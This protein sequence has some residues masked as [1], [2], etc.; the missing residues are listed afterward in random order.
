MTAGMNHV[1]E[2]FVLSAVLVV[3]TIRGCDT[4]RDDRIE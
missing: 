1:R 3:F 4:G 2:L